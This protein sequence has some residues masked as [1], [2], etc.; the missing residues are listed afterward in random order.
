MEIV[1]GDDGTDSEMFLA[2]AGETREL[3]TKFTDEIDDNLDFDR[4]DV[5]R[6]VID[7]ILTTE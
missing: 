1:T 6:F 4:G 7:P 3:D 5:D 2:L